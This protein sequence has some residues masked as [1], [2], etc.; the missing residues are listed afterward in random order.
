VGAARGAA[1]GQLTGIPAR[2][3]L[4]ARATSGDAPGPAP[5]PPPPPSHA[6]REVTGASHSRRKPL[7]IHSVTRHTPIGQAS[8]ADPRFAHQGRAALRNFTGA[9]SSIV[10]NLS[11]RAPPCRQA[12]AAPRGARGGGVSG[13]TPSRRRRMQPRV[14]IG[15]R[16]PYILG[17]ASMPNNA[18][19]AASVSRT[20]ATSAR[21]ASRS[22]GSLRNTAVSGLPRASRWL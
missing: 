8:R 13:G 22:P 12:V 19:V 15:G 2:L 1:A 4:P 9:R 18:S 5:D 6:I 20:L 7:R 16:R 17:G 11:L 3:Q 10:E 14:M 21:R